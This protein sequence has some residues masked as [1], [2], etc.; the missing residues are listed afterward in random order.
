MP[1]STCPAALV[2]GYPSITRITAGKALLPISEVVR[3]NKG[4]KNIGVVVESLVFYHIKSKYIQKKTNAP[5]E[6]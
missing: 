4:S 2:Y 3:V 1:V 6:N 5:E